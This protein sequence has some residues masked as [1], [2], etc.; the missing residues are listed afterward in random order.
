MEAPPRLPR[1][2]RGGQPPPSVEGA[3]S[4]LHSEEQVEEAEKGRKP[5]KD[6]TVKATIIRKLENYT[7]DAVLVECEEGGPLPRF[8]VVSATVAPFSGAETYI[9]A[10]NEEGEVDDWSEL[11]GSY[12]G[13]L[14][15][16][17]AL[18]GAGYE[19]A[20]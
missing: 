18:Q 4:L 15:H 19:L 12:R 7:G 20:P 5:G 2:A 1:R 16:A 11:D 6:G 13:G 10:A 3:D 9:F 14:N 17:E 8:V